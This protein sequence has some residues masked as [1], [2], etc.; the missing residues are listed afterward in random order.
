MARGSIKQRSPGT[1]YIR[2]ELE[3]DPVTGKRR[4]KAETL[5]GRK[6]DAEARMNQL[7]QDARDGLVGNAGRMTLAEFLDRW[8][9]EHVK[10]HLAPKTH[11]G[12]RQLVDT[13]IKPLIGGI[14]LDKLRAQHLLDFKAKLRT[15]PRR[16][17]KRTR[18]IPAAEPAPAPQPISS[19]TQRAAY[20]A[21]HTA[22]EHAVRWKL[23]GTNPASTIPAP[24]MTTAEMRPFTAEQAAAFTAAL[25]AEP[26]EWH[27]FFV[28]ALNTGM[29]LAEL[30]GL[31]WTDVELDPGVIR[32]RQTIAFVPGAGSS[33]KGSKGLVVKPPKT[34][35]GRRAIPIGRDLVALLRQHRAEQNVQRLQL[36]ARWKDWGLVFPSH[37]GTPIADGRVRTTFARVCA[38]AAVPK[39][40][41]H[42]L[43]HTCATLML[44][45]GINPKI[46]SERLGHAG[47]AITLTT[48]AHS[49]PTMQQDAADVLEA[50]LRS[51]TLKAAPELPAVINA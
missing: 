28:T 30:V 25:R 51:T 46:V 31:R 38:A 11:R 18:P 32:V 29:R 20:R 16:P 50:L 2:V 34:N 8:L 27:A 14:A 7:L 35:A 40:R 44:Q 1:W 23:I 26:I 48:Y 42:D 33:D 43:R 9:S 41:V 24:A 36:G 17:H 47:I 5:V 21:L 15:L 39:I 6:R 12:Y 37:I 45:A 3:P 19:R 4:Q 49:M 22:L 10:E 13:Q